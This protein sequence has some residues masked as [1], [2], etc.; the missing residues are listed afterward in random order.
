M[1]IKLQSDLSQANESIQY[2]KREVHELHQL[3][4]HQALTIRQLE[5]DLD[6]TKR[7][8][9]ET[10]R[11]ADQELVSLEDK[12]SEEQ[13]RNLNAVRANEEL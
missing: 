7:L 3:N 8:K 1:N 13:L 6:V 4:K 5:K 11:R 9:E 10:H 2:H 12:L